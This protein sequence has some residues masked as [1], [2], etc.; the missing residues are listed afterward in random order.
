MKAPQGNNSTAPRNGFMDAGLVAI[1]SLQKQRY[2]ASCLSGIRVNDTLIYSREQAKMSEE[3]ALRRR[4]LASYLRLSR[5]RGEGK[6]CGYW[7]YLSRYGAFDTPTYGTRMYEQVRS[8]R[9]MRA[10]INTVDQCRP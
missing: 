10:S 6:G 5:C 7:R 4:F 2:I 9:P 1:L 8:L 3:A